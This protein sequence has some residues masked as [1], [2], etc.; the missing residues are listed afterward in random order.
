VLKYITQKNKP[1]KIFFVEEVPAIISF[2]SKEIGSNRKIMGE[3]T[4]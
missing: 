1:F 3:N 4:L 2:L